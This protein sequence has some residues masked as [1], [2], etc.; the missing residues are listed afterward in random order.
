MV[1]YI[2]LKGN[3]DDSF[4]NQC[5]C[6]E[7]LLLLTMCKHNHQFALDTFRK[8]AIKLRDKP[9]LFIAGVTFFV[10]KK[11]VCKL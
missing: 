11:A 5:V 3:E 6:E 8:K 7:G 9:L 1:F 10:N 4:R 2:K